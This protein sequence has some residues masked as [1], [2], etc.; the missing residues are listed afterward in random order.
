MKTL[1]ADRSD[2]AVMEHLPPR[3][4]SRRWSARDARADRTALSRDLH[5]NRQ[6]DRHAEIMCRVVLVPLHFKKNIL[7]A[8][9]N[10][11]ED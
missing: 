5:H 11:L 8:L 1:I 10:H 9:S 6:L 3:E 2:Q 4:P 7:P